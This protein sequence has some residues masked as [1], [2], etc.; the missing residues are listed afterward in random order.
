[1]ADSL[2]LKG[3]LEVGAGTCV[4]ACGVA[5]RATYPIALR[6]ATGQQFQ[7]AVAT[8]ET[9]RISTPGAVGSSFADLSLLGDLTAIELLYC[10]SDQP[11]VLRI[12]A[13]EPE[14]TGSGGIFPT[15]FA[16]GETLLIDF[17]GTTVTTAFLV[18]DQTSAQVAARINAACALAGLP[19]PRVSVA[20][21]GQ[22]VIAGLGTGAS[23]TLSVTG[24][25]GAATLGFG[26]LPSDQGEGSDVPVWGTFLCEFGVAGSLPAPPERVQF[27]GTANL[28]IVAAG[29]TT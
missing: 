24:G 6:C 2:S 5:A 21:S 22:L 7:S 16:G 29:R 19:T 11:I 12:G 17:D 20:T 18:G 8:A 4:S 25:T 10:K 27:S 9:I 3:V 23:S 13:A 1:M 26:A 28:T 14:L 15:L